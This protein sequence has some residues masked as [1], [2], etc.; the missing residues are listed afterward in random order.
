M[1]LALGRRSH[2]GQQRSTPPV[3]C[4]ATSGAPSAHHRSPRAAPNL[5]PPLSQSG[6]RRDGTLRAR[7]I[8]Q[9]RAHPPLLFNSTPL[10]PTPP[11]F[12]SISTPKTHHATPLRS[13]RGHARGRARRAR[14]GSMRT[15]P[16]LLRRRGRVLTTGGQSGG[17]AN[18]EYCC[19]DPTRCQ[20]NPD[21]GVNDAVLEA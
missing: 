4:V 1:V 10:P 19:P 15:Y 3:A 18:G 12:P 21:C 11:A 16:P 9:R 20:S 13:D 5:V 6:M 17:C 2:A 8:K 14:R 7:C